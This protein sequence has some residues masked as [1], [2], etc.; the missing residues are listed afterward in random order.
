MD[1]L[2]AQE[3]LQERVEIS[4]ENTLDRA[5]D[6]KN[7]SSERMRVLFNE[8]EDACYNLKDYLFYV[9]GKT[10]ELITYDNF[11]DCVADL[12]NLG[13]RVQYH[14]AKNHIIL[15]ITWKKQ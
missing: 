9:I 11:K 15:Q 3:L 12:K 5:N 1:A 6:I 7:S 10:D 14:F 4:R 8:I 13:Y 2:N